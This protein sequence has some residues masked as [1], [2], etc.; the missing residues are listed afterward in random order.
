MMNY[1][2]FNIIKEALQSSYKAL[3]DEMEPNALGVRTIHNAQDEYLNALAYATS[4]EKE[5]LRYVK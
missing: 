5:Y 1:F 3:A 4:V 2:D